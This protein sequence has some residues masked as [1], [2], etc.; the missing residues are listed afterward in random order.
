MPH[1][2]QIRTII[3][4]LPQ[5]LS[6]GTVIVAV[7]CR[8]KGDFQLTQQYVEHS[9]GV[10]LAVTLLGHSQAREPSCNPSTPNMM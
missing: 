3:L 7:V 6:L 1:I 9:C 5:L 4:S 2:C 10:A 8:R